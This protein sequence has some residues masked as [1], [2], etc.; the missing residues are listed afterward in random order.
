M[1]NTATRLI[2]TAFVSALAVTSLG[3]QAQVASVQ[4]APSAQKSVPVNSLREAY[5]GQLHLHTGMSFDAFLIGTRLYPEDAYR[6]ARGES[7][8]KDG[9][10]WKLDGRPLDFLG[11]SDH[12]EY[13][14]Q[15][16][17]LDDPNGPLA[18]SDFK[19][20][21]DQLPPDKRFMALFKLSESFGTG[22]VQPPELLQ[23]DLMKT[24]WQR[25]IDAANSF[26]QPGKFTTFVAYEYSSLPNGA[27]LHRNVIFRGPNYPQLP[28]SSLDSANP[29]DLWRYIEHQRSQG[30][31]CLAIP[32]NSNVSDGLMFSY[33]DSSRRPID[34][35]YAET[36]VSIERLA[37]ITQSKGT[38]ETRPELSPND[39]FAGF[40]LIDNLL[41]VQRPSS[42]HGSYIRE[43][44][45]RGLEIGQRTGVNPFEF[46]LIGGSDFHSALADT[47]ERSLDA[48]KPT[49]EVEKLLADAKSFGGAG[50]S[51]PGLAGVWAE[52]NTR[53]SLYDALYRRE[54][55]AT[56]G[57][58][59]RIRFFAGFNYPA[60]I[61]RQRDWIRRAYQDGVPMGADFR[62]PQGAGISPRFL[63]QAVKDPDG[64]NLDRIQ[65]IKV[66]L[67]H[68]SQREKVY[69]VAWAGD[70]ALDANGKLPAIRSTVDT[71]KASYSN[72]VGAVQLSTEWQDPDFHA[73][74]AAVYYARVLE[75]PTPRWTTY[76]AVKN[77]LPVPTSV[78]SSIQERGWTSP[79]FYQ[80]H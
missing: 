55:F 71:A 7:I 1:I 67:D 80:G 60:G 36:R 35:E 34:R 52:S 61:L 50:G 6:Y 27:N 9:R 45:G 4:P 79:V 28:F 10:S 13:L 57:T 78:P 58:R 72:D 59:L 77:K 30:I 40:E 62:P 63:I 38:S 74:A 21:L 37:E 54:T 22:G 29:E 25:Q 69:D 39:D 49:A 48:D 41:T 26:Y 53:E 43:A 17:V 15:M 2:A 8:E 11:V 23:R 68:G 47:S 44:Y 19:K 24:N 75:I 33:A 31:Q 32:H 3:L 64:A 16:K 18:Q 14:G 66:W 46:G 70:R 65:I 73:D 5:F 20:K 12:A 42:I 76:L 51:S 56:S